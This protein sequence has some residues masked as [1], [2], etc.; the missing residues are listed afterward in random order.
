MSEAEQQQRAALDSL[1]KERQSLEGRIEDLRAFERE[2]RAK[3]KSHIES[4]LH[5]LDGG[6]VPAGEKVQ[7]EASS[8]PASQP[9][10]VQQESANYGGVPAQPQSGFPG[11]G[12]N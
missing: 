1:D 12:G 9:S 8:A 11:F 5:D 6:A 2:Y 10:P 7:A 4:I 3:L